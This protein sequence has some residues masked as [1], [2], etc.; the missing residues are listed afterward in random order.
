MTTKE[1]FKKQVEAAENELRAH[2]ICSI[3][4]DTGSPEE[5]L[6]E[7][8]DSIISLHKM[9]ENFRDQVGPD[10]RAALLEA[11]L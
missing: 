6:V 3:D 11:D 7:A 5:G 4:S 10:P 9:L 2:G 1:E 8:K